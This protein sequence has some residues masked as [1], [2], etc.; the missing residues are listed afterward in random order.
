MT[1]RFTYIPLFWASVNVMDNWKIITSET[2]GL[3]KLCIMVFFDCFAVQL[4]A[5]FHVNWLGH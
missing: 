4:W 2:L 1:T 5:M 3:S